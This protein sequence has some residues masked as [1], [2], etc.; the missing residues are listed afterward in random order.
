[1]HYVVTR[2]FNTPTYTSIHNEREK[3]KY[4]GTYSVSALTI[5]P[6]DI[7]FKTGPTT[8]SVIIR[9]GN[10]ISQTW[11]R[12]FRQIRAADTIGSPPNEAW[13]VLCI[14][15]MKEIL[16]AETAETPTL[17]DATCDNPHCFYGPK[18]YAVYRHVCKKC[19]KKRLPRPDEAPAPDNT[20]LNK[21]IAHLNDRIT[22]LETNRKN[23]RRIT[24]NHVDGDSHVD[25]VHGATQITIATNQL[26][27]VHAILKMAKALKN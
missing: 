5:D 24:H 12:S 11:A 26:A 25:M 13:M 9:Y 16:S 21:V 23:W 4:I 1:M 8:R 17:P 3:E 22:T 19:M 20:Q 10:N 2:L 14:H 18:T 15:I 27:E 6:L 7:Y